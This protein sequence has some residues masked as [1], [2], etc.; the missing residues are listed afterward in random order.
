[1]KTTDTCTNKLF[2][3]TYVDA[4]DLHEHARVYAK[5]KKDAARIVKESVGSNIEITEIE[6][7][8]N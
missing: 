6:E 7:Q 5:N 4:Y 2:I 8:T 3:V 1:M